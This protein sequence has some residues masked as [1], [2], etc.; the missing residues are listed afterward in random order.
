MKTVSYLAG[1]ALAGYTIL[2]LTACPS[3]NNGSNDATAAA[4]PATT[5]TMSYDGNLRNQ[6]GQ[7]CSSATLNGQ[8]GAGAQYINGQ[9]YVNGVAVNCGGSQYVIPPTG[10]AGGTYVT[11]CAQWSQYYP[12]H[13]YVPVNIGGGQLMCVD[14]GYLTSQ[15]NFS[16]YNSNYSSPSYWYSNPPTIYQCDPYY[17]CGGGGGG[18]YYGYGSQ[19]AVNVNLGYSSGSFGAGVNMCFD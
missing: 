8:C 6:Y 13:T 12:G 7:L 4:T 11:G 16:Q 3:T 1:L 14:Y 9:Y 5:C 18:G 10:Y 17:G 19:C 2:A 15:Y